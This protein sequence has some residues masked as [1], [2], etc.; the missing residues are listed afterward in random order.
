MTKCILFCLSLLMPLA[1][2]CSE[3]ADGRVVAVID[4]DT[5]TVDVSGKGHLQ[6]R[7]AW[8]DAPD[9]LQDHGEAARASLGAMAGGQ[10]V[11]LEGLAST[12]GQWFAT[13]WAVAP[14]APC[15]NANCPKTLDLGLAQITR[16]LAWHER[17]ALGQSPQ[18]L[19]QYEQAEFQAKIRRIGLWAGKNPTPPWD[20][21]GR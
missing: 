14:G 7:L 13:I 10:A 17:R 9:R 8:A 1:A 12:K 15:A 3:S 5:L 11:R 4:G 20:W 19:G 16:G 18:A 6:V 21:R 2:T